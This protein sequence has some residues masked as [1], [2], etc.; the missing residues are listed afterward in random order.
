MR[1]NKIF[2]AGALALMATNHLFSATGKG[3]ITDSKTWTRSFAVNKDADLNLRCRESDV[4]IST[5]DRNE[6]E[7]NVT[8]TVE[9]YEQEE[10]DKMLEFFEPNISGN[11]SGVN[12]Q[13]PD[14]TSE[15]VRN[16]RTK[17]KINNQI[18]K[19]KKYRYQFDIKMPE[20]NDLNA[21]TRFSIV[22]LGSHRAKVTLE[23]YE[24]T[25]EADQINMSEGVCDLK[26]CKGSLGAANELRLNTYESDLSL[27]DMGKL[28][29][30]A[31]FS[32][33]KFDRVHEAKVT[34]YESVID[35][36]INHTADIK[37]NFGSLSM[38][39]S[40]SLNLT[41]Y[42][43]SLTAGR[44]KVLKIPNGRF[45]KIKVGKTISAEITTAYESDIT[46]TE[47][48]SIEIDARFCKLDVGELKY[49]FQG[50]SYESDIHIHQIS[51]ELSSIE[52]DARFSSAHF[53][54]A[55]NQQYQLEADISFGGIKIP[56]VD[57]SGIRIDKQQSNFRANG[58]S[59]NYTGDTRIRISGYETNVVLSKGS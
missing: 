47:S 4:N 19:V 40:Q 57:M 54:M 6:I 9:A 37:H 50:E 10:L 16:K 26:F 39:E 51:P 3:I 52:L 22:K 43:M 35:L 36:G 38:A 1:L 49:S 30:D 7:V 2:L 17:I 12:V 20:T 34:A 44:I 15:E 58:G 42:E 31:K 48:E 13:N 28:N 55:E 23:F 21:N 33:L 45:S 25:I 11:A 18:I 8:L 59:Q 14:C 29:M 46:I 56:E 32:E 5:W 41:A 24:C 27:R 53:R